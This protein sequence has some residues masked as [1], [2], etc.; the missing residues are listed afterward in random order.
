MNWGMES[1]DCLH[2]QSPD[3][4]KIDFL[5]TEYTDIRY[6]DITPCIE[7]QWQ[8]GNR[9]TDGPKELGME[10]SDLLT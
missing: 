1:S 4:T 5:G 7:C 2:N 8:S 6:S 10:S 9:G 3:L